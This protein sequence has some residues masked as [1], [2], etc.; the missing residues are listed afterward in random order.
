[1][2]KTNFDFDINKKNILTTM[3]KET[4]KQKNTI[5]FLY[6]WL[7]RI[8]SLKTEYILT[9]N[10]AIYFEEIWIL[11]SIKSYLARTKSNNKKYSLFFFLFQS[12]L[13]R[14]NP[15]FLRSSTPQTCSPSSQPLILL[16]SLKTGSTWCVSCWKFNW[17]IRKLKSSFILE[18]RERCLI[19]QVCFKLG[20]KN[21]GNEI[22]V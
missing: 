16:V 6:F 18:K 11:L 9:W 1:M 21:G 17:I 8:Y 20:L 19:N 5:L 10:H 3:D 7:S 12:K 4:N 13:F 15:S 22:R 2:R 14:P